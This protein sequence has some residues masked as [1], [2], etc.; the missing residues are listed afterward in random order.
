MFAAAVLLAGTAIPAQAQTY[1]ASAQA[2]PV[3]FPYPST[4]IVNN[5]V[6]GSISPIQ[7][8]AVG[9]F[10]NDS[11]LDTV[12]VE[13]PGGYLEIDVA[14]GNGDG[15][16]QSPVVQN[17]FTPGQHTPY[18]MAVADFN[19]DGHLDVAV[20]GIYA[21]GNTSEVMI[22]QGN[23]NGTFTYS[24]TYAAPNSADWSE[25]PNTLYVADFNGDG[26]LDLAALTQYNGV[27]L[28]FGNGDGTFQTAVGYS[29]VDPN[30]P[31]NYIAVG[32]AVG[33][34]NG[35]GKLDIAVTESNGM[36]VLLNNGNGTFGTATYYASGINSQSQMGIAIGDVN[37][38]KKNDIV[39]TD[40]LGDVVL[41]LNQGSGT[42]AVKGVVA[43]LTEPAWQVSIADI[44]GD[45]KLD[46]VVADFAGEVFTYY[47]KGNGT[48][49]AGPVYPLQYWDQPPS[50][51][52]LADFNGDG[53]LDLFKA[54]D[55]YLKGQVTLGRG[56][57]TFQTNVAY[58]RGVTGREQSC[59]RR[60]QRRRLPGRGVLRRAKQE[61]A[62]VR[63]HV[64]QLA[65][66]LGGANLLDLP[67]G[68]VQRQL[69][70]V[71]CRRRRERRWQS[72][73]RGD[74]YQL[75]KHRLS[76]QRSRRLYRPR[77]GEI[78]KACV[79]FDGRIGA[80]ERC[81]PRRFEWRWPPGHRHFQHRWHHQPAAQ[82]G[83]G[84]VRYRQ[85]HQQRRRPQPPFECSG[86]CR[87]QRRWKARHR[88]RILLSGLLQ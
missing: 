12:S 54:G 71:D 42:F 39:T 40:Y 65:R 36:A 17:L 19:G 72:R 74:H 5:D 52:I 79:L 16:F 10:N 85:P 34:L 21:A 31:N 30:H 6:G 35:D 27:Y 20:W 68:H 77:H 29:T 25:S 81:V 4:I 18:A 32:M 23:G 51:V 28:Y 7:A 13:A 11:K 57:G 58:G 66:C 69:P 60:L 46:L 62:G 76:H 14:L 33:D 44:N 75:P 38:D 88:S 41:F 59:R 53:A 56:D 45:K 37:K 15:T 1:P 8:A 24:N 50:N 78:Q 64:R 26:K 67:L 82:Q 83:Q 49:A 63:S 86:H 80:I 3:A 47:G 70:R 22:F 87:F 2:Y 43:T 9:D 73:Y 84:H 61:C 48:F 55:H